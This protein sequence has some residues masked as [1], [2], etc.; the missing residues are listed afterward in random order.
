M[1]RLRQ[2]PAHRSPAAGGC[3]GRR[4]VA[5][6]VPA[7]LSA[8]AGVLPASANA[9][10]APEFRLSVAV[11]HTLPL[12]RAAERWA[13]RMREGPA[14]IA[15]KLYPGASLAQRDPARE[16][17]ALREGRADLAVGSSLQWSL[18]LPALGVFS[19]PWI[20]PDDT[21]LAA[22]TGDAAL[23]ERLAARMAAQ[24]LALV[25]IAPLGY[26]EVANSVRPIRAPADIAGLRLRAAAS[27]LLQD[28]LRAL[29]A[30][31]QSLPFAQ[32]QDAFR[33]GQLD[34]QEG[35][36]TSLAAARVAALGQRYVTDLGGIA[37]AMVFAVRA[38]VW[39]GWTPAQRDQSRRAAALAIEDAQAL[40]AE[41]AALRELAGQGA[42][43]LR[44]TP[45]GQVAFREATREVASRWRAN[46]G[47]DVVTAAE[48]VL[49]PPMPVVVP[50]PAPA[51]LP[52]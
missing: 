10:A 22:L 14:P 34:G 38:E 33:Q 12:G 17:P 1:V 27:P 2:R 52:K 49:A 6:A 50:P 39:G 31:P 23:R 41:Q 8:L 7:V 19:L 30:Q 45:A 32:A 11:G 35:S 28:I 25:A 48:R 21:Q 42:G 4:L 51:E 13:Q 46:V 47:E 20:C 5:G 26:R 36:P 9:Q 37:E 16:V 43:V 44:L 24:G 15:A 29:G 18:Q 3:A 40:V